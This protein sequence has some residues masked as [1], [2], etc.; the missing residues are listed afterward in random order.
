M[1]EGV[2][3]TFAELADLMEPEWFVA[4]MVGPRWGPITL[5]L[6]RTEPQWWVLWQHIRAIEGTFAKF[7]AS[8]GDG[9]QT[10]T[11]T[12]EPKP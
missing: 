3:S 2:I 12:L 1:S 9:T 7:A 8:G 11:I 4:D 10:I 6:T 5:T